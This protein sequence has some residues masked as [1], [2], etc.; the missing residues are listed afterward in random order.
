MTNNI[1]LLTYFDKGSY[2]H[3]F[4][5]IYNNVY[6]ITTII[7][8]ET[9]KNKINYSLERNNLIE[10]I[11]LNFFNYNNTLETNVYLPLSIEK[12]I[13]INNNEN[14]KNCLPKLGIFKINNKSNK[15]NNLIQSNKT[16]YIKFNEINNYFNFNKNFSN[17]ENNDFLIINKFTKLKKIVLS[18]SFNI[19]YIINKFKCYSEKL[20]IAISTLHKN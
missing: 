3:I 11:M 5:D 9:Y 20:L 4:K 10:I 13:Y 7:I 14:S 12:I 19:K 1:N 6:K 2:G 17:K 16:L 18:K 8:S 15:Y